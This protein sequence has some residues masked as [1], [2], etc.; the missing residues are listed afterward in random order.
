MER[1][2]L[3]PEALGISESSPQAGTCPRERRQCRRS[4]VQKLS[5]ACHLW[6]SQQMFLPAGLMHSEPAALLGYPEEIW[7]SLL[8]FCEEK[9]ASQRTTPRMTLATDGNMCLQCPGSRAAGR[10]E[11]HCRGCV[12]IVSGLCPGKL[13]IQVIC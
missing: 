7:S 1:C 4:Q 5:G 13:E 10:R 12:A 9:V 2:K 11:N 6:S 3:I 8:C